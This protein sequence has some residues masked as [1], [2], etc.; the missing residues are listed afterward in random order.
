MTLTSHHPWKLPKTF[1]RE[2]YFDWWSHRDLNAFLNTVRYMD[3]WV[4]RVLGYL[5]EA[6][7]ADR[8]L[9]VV[10]GDQYVSPASP[11]VLGKVLLYR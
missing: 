4:G 6:G 2:N 11:V 8:S 5:E 1:E 10:V 7:I 3:S 9:V